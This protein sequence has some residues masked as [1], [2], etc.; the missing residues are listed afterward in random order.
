MNHTT[1]TLIMITVSK[2][3]YETPRSQE[4]LTK[5]TQKMTVTEKIKEFKTFKNIF[6]APSDSLSDSMAARGKMPRVRSEMARI[7][8]EDRDTMRK[9]AKH[10]Y[11][12]S[13]RFS[14]RGN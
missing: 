7:V 1:V 14:G 10:L 11:V 3:R 12:I 8:R 13:T 2:E 9:L 6:R 4:H 5:R